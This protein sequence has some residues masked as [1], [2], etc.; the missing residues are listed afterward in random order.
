MCQTDFGS[1]RFPAHLGQRVG[2]DGQPT[3]IGQLRKLVEMQ[4]QNKE[5]GA[6][7]P[8]SIWLGDF[9]ALTRTDYD[10]SEWREVAA[11]RARSDWEAPVSELTG[12]ITGDGGLPFVDARVAAREA[13][14]PRS[15]C[16]FVS[17][18]DGCGGCRPGSSKLVEPSLAL[19]LELGRRMGSSRVVSFWTLHSERALLS[20]RTPNAHR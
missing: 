5:Q 4:E 9:N 19:V 2:D 14:G 8:R 12:A 1:K 11:V 15:T 18:R 6:A 17:A 10:E 7:A 16:R 3:R 20:S 13:P